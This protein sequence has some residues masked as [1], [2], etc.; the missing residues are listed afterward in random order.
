[1]SELTEQNLTRQQAE[2]EM[3]CLRKIYASVR[4]LDPKTL[5]EEPC[6]P[7]WKNVHPCTSCVGREA[8]AGKCQCSKLET[9]GSS[10]YQVTARYVEV[11]GKPYVM[12][13]ILP[14]DASARSSLH[15]NELIYRD[16]LTGAYN[17]RFYE[18]ELKHKYLNAGVAMIDLDDFKLC[19]DTY[20]H[21]AGDAALRLITSII[22]RCIRS[23]DMLVRYGGDELLLILPD[24][25]A[26]AFVRKLKDINKRLFA[27]H[28]P[29]FEKLHVSAS[30]GGAMAAGIPISDALLIADKRMY[31]A[32][33]RK[34]T[35]V[36]ADIAPDAVCSENEHRPMVL[37]VDDSPMN[38]DI[39][40]EILCDDFEILEA[41]NGPKCLELLN[42]WSSDISIV[43]LDI[44]LLDIV[45]PDMD[46]FDVLSRMSAQG[47]LE[48]IPVVMISSEDSS[49][50]VRRAYE[51]GASDYISRPFDARIVHR[52]V[53]NVARLYAR[54]RRLSALVSQ[55]F[56]DREKNDQIMIGI[57][58]QVTEIH[59]SESIHHISRVQ[60]IT[61]I[62]L[63]RLCQKTDIY[64]LSGMDRYLITTASALHDIGKV[65][66]D[67]RILNAHDLTPEQT[68][69]LHTHPI[70]GA[71]ML[72]NLSQ[73][74]DEPL[75][76]F[77][78][79]ICRWH[80]ER[81]DGSG[82]PDGRK[83]DDIPI[84]AQVV[85]L[86]DA[87]DGLTGK[88]DKREALSQEE[89]VAALTAGKHGAFNPLLLE[90][91][92]DV[93]SRLAEETEADAPPPPKEG[94]LFDETVLG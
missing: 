87:Y 44:V 53:S 78:I 70:L 26:E 22:H 91:L 77:A 47:W 56:Y 27:A 36:T 38:R 9:L 50:T 23:T 29:E 90:C 62:L 31:L 73:Y 42:A 94:I 52:R 20:G 71:Q 19:N 13:M 5:A 25:S 14:L 45:M 92:R 64:G 30:I 49:Q 66:I 54:Q 72:E 37:I 58:S 4:L 40:S 21:S 74:Q 67:D 41:P 82:Y 75:V 57:L 63:E 84:A 61:S 33:R 48:D 6:Y 28:L 3:A 24:I 43:L 68:A 55:Q 12:E 34:N 76:K 89:A 80:H 83:S 8:M 60:R 16:A 39:L 85:A 2:Q 69:I 79:Q 18:E 46:G 88:R 32:K 15:S 93:E 7:P 11:D 51:L 81:W 10:L 1:M 59:N 65:A 86:A 35:V 17:R